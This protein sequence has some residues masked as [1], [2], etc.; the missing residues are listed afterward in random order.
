VNLATLT[1]LPAHVEEYDVGFTVGNK[2]TVNAAATKTATA[3]VDAALQRLLKTHGAVP[4]DATAVSS[5]GL[6]LAQFRD[7]ARY[8]LRQIAAE[9]RDEDDSHR[10]FD[11]WRAN[12]DLSPWRKALHADFLLMIWAHD[13]HATTGNAIAGALVGYRVTTS[14]SD[15]ACVLDLRDG[16]FVWCHGGLLL[17]DLRTPAGAGEMV[18]RLLGELLAPPKLV[19]LPNQP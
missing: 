18:N 8:T 3:H 19:R 14:T 1:A 16:R 15:V 9:I 17:P 6:P 12:N 10:E 11:E 2:A 4:F 13:V 7:W 5:S